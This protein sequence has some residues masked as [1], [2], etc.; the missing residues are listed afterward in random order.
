[1]L[2]RQGTMC[3]IGKSLELVVSSLDLARTYSGTW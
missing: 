2:D 1:M 3:M